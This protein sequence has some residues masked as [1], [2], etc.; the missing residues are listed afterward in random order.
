MNVYEVR[1]VKA[2]E[3]SLQK[4][5]N[6][7]L[8]FI[9]PIYQRTYSWTN[10]QCKQLW[11]D[12][13]TI[14]EKDVKKPHF[15][16][17]I[18]YIDMGM[19]VGKPQQLLLIDGQQRLTTLSL[20]L[21]AL[22]RY[23][24]DNNL[25][26]KLSA[27]KIINYF[28]LNNEEK[29]NDRYKLLLTDQDR[30]TLI[31]LLDNAEDKIEDP[32][33]RILEN[34][35]FFQKL[36]EDYK[37]ITKIFEGLN[38]LILVSVALDKEH[39]NPQLIFESMNSTGKDLSQADLIRNYILMGLESEEQTRLYKHYW[40]TM[41]R[42]FGQQGYTDYFDWFIRDFLTTQNGSGRI[43]KISEVYDVF[44]EYYKSEKSNEEILQ[45]LYAYSKYYTAMHLGK[46]DDKELKELW[47]QLKI[48]DVSVSY[49]FLMR[50]Y[51]DYE[52]EVV[53]KQDFIAII[54]AT[55]SYVLR[56]VICEVP[57]NSLNK[58]FA[59]F[60]KKIKIE[61]YLQSVLFEY[62]SKDSYRAFPKDDE[63]IEKLKTKDIYN[64]KIKNYI[65]ESLENHNHKE[66]ISIVNKGLTVEHIMPQ[67]SSL[68]ESWKNMLGEHWQD[69]H[70]IYLHTIGNLTLTA[71]NSSLS[72]RPFED[73]KKIPGGFIDSHLRLNNKIS[74]LDKW[75]EEAILERTQ[76]LAQQ[77]TKIWTYPSINKE[78]INKC[79]TNNEPE[80]IYRDLS[81]YSKMHPEIE[82]IY[83]KL[84]R[85]I[86]GLDSGINKEF[87]KVYI[88]YKV[89]TNFVDIEPF[90]DHF[91]LWLNMPFHEI[92]DG[93]GICVDV[94]KIN[95]H[96][97]GDVC[98]KVS[99]DSD[100]AYVLSLIE[101]ALLFQL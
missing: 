49:P 21:C 2:V 46:E 73:K 85:M 17:S 101:Q 10:K 72:D 78:Y 22:A 50:V 57:T 66:P 99:R 93:K 44:K 91:K 100:L 75:N 27:N 89:D 81:H 16:G 55:I 76:D 8:Q 56:R 41:E 65:L 86:M 64:L 61:N 63:V 13:I 3:T 6:G 68:N 24:K 5:T 47:D 80:I 59:T 23:I 97:N 51:Y 4:L 35:L 7:A 60:Y 34:F 53:N 28:L 32:S 71:Y 84:D 1:I 39:D 15:I 20:L 31:Y 9:V 38:H 19:P 36:I 40:R 25:E 67:N 87:K 77:I 54:K 95:H 82:S 52:N 12:I 11:R 69:I 96:G 29:D 26:D 30:E 45:E 79:L 43:C 37:D 14:A 70:R 94:T 42:R 98:V 58:T 48:L 90:S 18:V 33:I 74:L 62:V 88:A 92:E 83:D